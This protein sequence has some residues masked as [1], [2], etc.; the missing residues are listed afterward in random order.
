MIDA[1]SDS[2]ITAGLTGASLVMDGG[3]WMAG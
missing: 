2:R 3:T 1:L